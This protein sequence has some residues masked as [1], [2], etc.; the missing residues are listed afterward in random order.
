MAGVEVHVGAKTD[1]AVRELQSFQKK[2]QGIAKSIARGFKERVGHKLFDGLKSA[3]RQMPRIMMDAVNAAS[4][5]NEELGKSEAVF[6]K[7]SK[8]VIAWSKTT[9]MAFGISRGEA[10]QATGTMGNMLRAFGITGDEASKMSMKLV[11]LAGDFASFNNATVEDTI[12]AIGA[13]LRGESEPIRK[14]A[15]DLNDATLKAKAFDLGL[16]NGEKALSAN[17]KALAAYNIILDET[18][19]QQGD[20]ARTSGNLA[21]QKRILTAQVK[22]LQ[23]EIGEKLLPV[24]S[25][26]ITKLN[27]ADFDQIAKDVGTLTSAFADLAEFTI[28]ATKGWMLFA[29]GF[30]KEKSPEWMDK[31]MLLFPMIKV[32]DQSFKAYSNLGKTDGFEFMDDPKTDS[33]EDKEKSPWGDDFEKD[34]AAEKKRRA[35]EKT[36]KEQEKSMMKEYDERNKAALHAERERL[37]LL[38]KQR[39]EKE[40]ALALEKAQEGIDRTMG[41]VGEIQS[42]LNSAMTRSSITAVSSMQAIGGGGGVSGEL[43]LQKTQTDLQRQLVVLNKELVDAFREQAQLS[44]QPVSQ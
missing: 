6:G 33:S 11:E 41:Q 15:V 29:E 32:F 19:N 30:G 21:G 3:V 18:K 14:Y 2:T 24:V 16:Y 7:F 9:T 10:L 8:S 44:K 39:Q 4:D 35:E 20:A 13:A 31:M 23:V 27:E 12:Y 37:E 5:M 26:L 38:E 42:G 1:K 43:N 36:W 28:K 17:A 25:D 34:W 22:D 40:K